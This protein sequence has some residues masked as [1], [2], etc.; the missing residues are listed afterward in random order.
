MTIG[1]MDLVHSYDGE[2]RYAHVISAHQLP[3]SALGRLS[4]YEIGEQCKVK[5]WREIF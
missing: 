5:P 1:M 4:K 2:T 3:K